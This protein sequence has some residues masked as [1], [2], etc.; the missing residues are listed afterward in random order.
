MWLKPSTL[1]VKGLLNLSLNF[2]ACLVNT[3][4]SCLHSRTFQTSFQSAKSARRR[5]LSGV[6]QGGLV[7]PVPFS[8]YVNDMPTPSR[9]VEIAQHTDDPALVATPANHRCSSVTWRFI[10]ADLST[11]YRAEGLLS[12]SQTALRFPLQRLQD[13]S[14]GPDQPRF[15]ESQYCGSK[16][17]GIS[18]WPLIHSWPGRHM[19]TRL[20]KRQLGVL[21]SLPNRRSGLFI[22]NCV[23]L[24]KQLIRLWWATHASSGG[25]LLAAMSGSRK[26]CNPGVFA[27]RLTHLGTLVT[28]KCTRIWGSHFMPTTSEQ[29][30]WVSTQS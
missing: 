6:V 28:G 19:P 23:L 22:R 13:A 26:C 16:Q 1:C 10:S 24:Y 11:G 7:T 4:S 21:D 30:L 29:W 2:Y 20:E 27:L 18:G 9:H 25:P 14:K 5:M 8:L 3:L 15:S 17:C 12:T